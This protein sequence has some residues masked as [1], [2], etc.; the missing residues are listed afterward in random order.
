[1]PRSTLD[2]TNSSLKLSD[3]SCLSPRTKDPSWDQNISNTF[4]DRPRGSVSAAGPEAEFGR[5]EEGKL[6]KTPNP[7]LPIEER[8]A[9]LEEKISQLKS[10]TT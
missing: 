6:P 1:M 10:T 8:I 9:F 2:A 5:P 4:Q 3:L 7:S